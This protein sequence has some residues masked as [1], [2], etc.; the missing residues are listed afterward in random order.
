M[1]RPFRLNLSNT[2]AILLTDSKG[3]KDMQAILDNHEWK[4]VVNDK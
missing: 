2:I 3:R 1:N 4:I